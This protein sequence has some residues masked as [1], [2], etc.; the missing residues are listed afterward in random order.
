MNREIEKITEVV[1]EVLKKYNVQIVEEDDLN[2]SIGI[3]NRHLHLC[4]AD[5]ETLFGAG[6]ELT[7]MKDLNQPGQY[8]CKETVTLAGPKGSI[9]KVRVL[10]PARS[11][12]QIEL[13]AG[14]NFTLGIHAPLRISGDTA[15]S[16]PVTVIGPK[17]SIYLKEGA[18]VA[19][20]HIHMT[21]ADAAKHGVKDG[22][23]VSAE[24]L[25]ERGGVLGNVIIRSN[26]KSATECHLDTEE[27][28]A[29]GVTSKTVL[30]IVK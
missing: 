8:A 22:D 9:E 11:A 24:I 1:L 30:K 17:G 16:A 3:S 25:G 26:D 4:Q 13:L 28:N 5:L 15:G 29:F 14:D 27:A 20:R 12:S 2:I 18:I 6:Y 7:P 23:V 10:G 19:Q 21:P